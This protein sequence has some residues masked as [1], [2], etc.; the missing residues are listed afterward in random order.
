MRVLQLGRILPSSALQ[1]RLALRIPTTD[2]FASFHPPIF[3]VAPGADTML[4]DE[5]R[6]S[7]RVISYTTE[8][9]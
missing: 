5:R 1:G 6:V 4:P 3:I 8:E 9:Q 7:P 2:P